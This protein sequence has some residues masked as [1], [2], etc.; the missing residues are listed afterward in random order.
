ME[1]DCICTGFQQLQDMRERESCKLPDWS[2]GATMLSKCKKIVSSVNRNNVV[3]P[4]RKILTE[5][6][7]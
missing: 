6:N 1:G 7:F 2:L 5:G 3:S 4:K